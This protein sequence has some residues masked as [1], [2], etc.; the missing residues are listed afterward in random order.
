MYARVIT[1]KVQREAA[2]H[3]A[4]HGQE[5]LDSV[6]TELPGFNGALLL[7]DPDT[8]KTLS[9]TLWR[10]E[11]DEQAGEAQGFVQRQLAALGA[12]IAE[13]QQREQY[14]VSYQA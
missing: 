14:A 6:A 5:S 11:A 1:L 4:I 10:S 12:V 9:I 2:R 8:G 3:A 7:T 13:P